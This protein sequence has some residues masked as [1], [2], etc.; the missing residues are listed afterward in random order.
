MYYDHLNIGDRVTWKAINYDPSGTVVA[1]T[2]KGLLVAVDGGG[3]VL[4]STLE[5]ET[6]E[7]ERVKNAHTAQRPC[8]PYNQ[9]GDKDA[10]AG[11]S[12]ATANKY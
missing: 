12:P 9:K 10:G 2:D 8:H 11:G 5:A 6:R 4:L 3:H 7:R 1:K